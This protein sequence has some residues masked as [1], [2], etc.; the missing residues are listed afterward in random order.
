MRKKEEIF[1]LKNE[2]SLM[3]RL[4]DRAWTHA[5]HYQTRSIQLQVE[6]D[7][8]KREIKRIKGI[9]ILEAMMAKRTDASS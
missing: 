5:D 6:N 2:I 8:L 3:G 1:F 9:P 7:E 4:C